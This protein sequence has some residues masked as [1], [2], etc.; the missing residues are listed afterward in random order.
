MK[1][2]YIDDSPMIRSWLINLIPADIKPQLEILEA[3]DGEE[4]LR[5]YKEQ[6]PAIVFLDLTMPKMSG[7]EV[8]DS[9]KKINKDTIVAIV[10][11]DRQNIT[12]EKV[13]KAG[14][15]LILHKPI[16]AVKKELYISLLRDGLNG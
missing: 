8:L 4:G 13:M 9:I 15:S 3:S 10:T 5:I 11:A 12:T 6:N 7:F 16:D 14:A 1:I 2:L